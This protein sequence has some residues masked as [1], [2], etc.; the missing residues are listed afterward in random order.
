M[1]LIPA[2][3]LK[4]GNCVRLYQG[5]KDQETKYSEDPVSMALYWE[6]QGAPRLHL[7]DLD[8]A[9]EEESANKAI[10]R[11]I[12]NKVNIPCQVGGGLRSERAIDTLLTAGAAGVIIGTAGVKNPD[13]LC[14]LVEK[15]GAEKI[16]AGVDC[17][18]G[19]VMIRG[20]Q[21]ASLLD[22]DSWLERL[23]KIGVEKI[24]YTDVGKDGTEQG[25]DTTGLREILNN[26]SLRVVASGGIGKLEHLESLNEIES[27][28]LTGVIVGKA[29]YERNFTLK[30]A[31]KAL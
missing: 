16:I 7:V 6:S 11:E 24:V 21:E 27:P 12:L 3:D 28:N 18:A 15:F 17:E 10:I 14:S 4:A 25:P 22:R 20:W 31:L 30:Q 8:G 26:T 1:E 29:L 2:I 23:E 9:F 13:W 5:K 19:E